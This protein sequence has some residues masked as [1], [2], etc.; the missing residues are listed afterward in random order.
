MSRRRKAAAES[1]GLEQLPAYVVKCVDDD[2]RR[3][4]AAALNQTGGKRLDEADA[5]RAA[6]T[7]ERL[8][9]SDE[10]VALYVGRSVASV[11]NYRAD[12]RF[13]ETAKLAGLDDEVP[14][15]LPRPVRRKP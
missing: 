7:L 13:F 9:L 11:R 12:R 3:G 15:T 4:L 2:V 6:E 8:G 1:I 14:A 5:M 10:Q